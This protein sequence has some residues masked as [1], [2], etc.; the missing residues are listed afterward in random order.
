MCKM[1]TNLAYIKEA[2]FS[3]P[4]ELHEWTSVVLGILS[5]GDKYLCSASSSWMGVL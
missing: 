2:F 1:Q 4:E 5:H 3:L